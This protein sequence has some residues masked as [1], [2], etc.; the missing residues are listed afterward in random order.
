ME[1]PDILLLMTDQH[2]GD[3]LSCAG[4]P[5]VQTPHLDWLAAE[6][7][8]FS[9]AYA[10]CPVCV[11]VRRTLMTGRFPVNH[12][13]VMNHIPEVPLP[14]PTLPEML[15]EHGY[16]THL[17]GKLHLTPPRKLHGF[18]SADWADNAKAP[19]E[20]S[21]GR[22][23]VNDYQRFLLS[24]GVRLPGFSDAHG[25]SANTPITRPWHAE[26]RLHFTNWV[27]DRAVE[28]LDRRDPTMP[29]FL[30]V[31]YLHPHPPCTPPRFYYDRYV[32]AD[33]PPRPVGHW[34][35]VFAGP[36]HGHHRDPNRICLDPAMQRRLEAGYYGSINHI[37]D[38]INRILT[39]LPHPKNTLI[40][41]LSDHGEMLGDHQWFRKHTPW[42]GSAHIPFIVVPPK[43]WGIRPGQVCDAPVQLA[44]IM[45]TCLAAAGIAIPDSVDGSDLLPAIEGGTARR[46]FVHGECADVATL[47]SGMH[48]VTDGKQK[49]IWFPGLG[50]EQFFDLTADPCELDNLA[51]SSES[52]P[53]LHRWRERL[54]GVL[55]ERSEG[56]VQRGRLARLDGPTAYYLHPSG[57]RKSAD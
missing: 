13:V 11:P 46:E 17:C 53:D 19:P 52:T 29:F 4:H 25:L 1:R 49:Y 48:F 26:E 38:Q 47:N 23:I 9:H 15:T 22:A 12:G 40:I 6:G 32:H 37:D 36:H 57:E 10:E 20:I 45:P 44:D 51:G 3:C 28:F 41:F 16:Q 14:G 8:R 27:T 33:M 30:K 43:T 34:A 31:S 2:R 21:N 39:V 55:Q 54:I 24:E 35:R 5:V 50:E 18:M 56:F 7:V 42:E